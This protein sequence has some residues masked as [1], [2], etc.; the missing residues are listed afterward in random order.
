MPGEGFVNVR[1]VVLAKYR[2]AAGP[3]Y[4]VTYGPGI[5]GIC[6]VPDAQV[7]PYKPRSK[8]EASNGTGEA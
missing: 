8:K 7:K 1:S 4:V 5:N 2:K 6:H 3:T